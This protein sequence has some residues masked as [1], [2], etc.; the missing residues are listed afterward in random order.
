MSTFSFTSAK[1]ITNL[2]L[3]IVEKNFWMG[4]VNGL[5]EVSSTTSDCY[6]YTQNMLDFIWSSQYAFVYDQFMTLVQEKGIQ[7]TDGGFQS[8][9]FESLVDFGLLFFNVYN[10]CYMDNLL[11]I[12][13]K[14]TSGQA[15]AGDYMLNLGTEFYA[16]YQKS[17]ES[18]I[19][20]LETA[21][22]DT[23]NTSYEPIG[24]AIG[25]ILT[26]A[27]DYSIPVYIYDEYGK[28]DTNT[29]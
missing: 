5:Q 7:G 13:G 27:F 9:V 4:I 18:K 1:L 15:M 3:L 6:S 17:P 8:Q 23:T 21:L 20:L 16:Y 26:E 11:Q 12:I 29:A 19:I 24:Y 10:S 28:A 14:M 2:S 25:A 22:K